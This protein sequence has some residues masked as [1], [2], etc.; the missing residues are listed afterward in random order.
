LRKHFNDMSQGNLTPHTAQLNS[1]VNLIDHH[2]TLGVLPS[3]TGQAAV[4]M[5]IDTLSCVFEGRNAPEVK[6]LEL[7]L[8]HEHAGIFRFPGGPRLSSW[9]CATVAAMASTWSEACEGLPN[10]HGRPGL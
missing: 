5:L 4:R 9:S 6:S 7:S 10:A 1:I 2:S 3:S 8:G